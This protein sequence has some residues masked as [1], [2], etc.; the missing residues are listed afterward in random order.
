MN[1]V[2]LDVIASIG[3][4]VL[5]VLVPGLFLLSSPL[6]TGERRWLAGGLGAWFLLVVGL[7]AAGVFT[8]GALGT[9]AIGLAVVLPIVV[10]LV[11]SG[12]SATLRKLATETPLSVMVALHAGRLLGVQF[13][14]LMSAHRLPATFATSAGVGDMIVAILSIPLAVAIYRGAPGW[15]RWALAWNILGTLDLV[16]AVTLGTGS[17][18]ESPLR[19]IHQ[20]PDSGLMGTLPWVLIPGFMVPCYLILH[21]FIFRRLSASAAGEA[22]REGHEAAGLRVGS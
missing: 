18:P 1:T 11:A 10:A 19:F 8:A 12:K 22:S 16:T 14:I 17:A 4:G 7:A 15:R 6:T 20:I 9:P 13:L 2:N 5:A 21:A 3:L